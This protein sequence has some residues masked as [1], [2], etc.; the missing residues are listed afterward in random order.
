MR[1]KTS[2]PK[3]LSV[4]RREILIALPVGAVVPGGAGRAIGSR[5]NR[6]CVEWNWPADGASRPRALCARGRGRPL[7]QAETLTC[8]ASL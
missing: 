6:I 5:G 1:T 2:F 3:I 4:P 7:R 8:A